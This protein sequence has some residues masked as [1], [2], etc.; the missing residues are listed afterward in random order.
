MGIETVLAPENKEDIATL[1]QRKEEELNELYAIHKKHLD[2]E[3]GDSSVDNL[4]L[5]SQ[6]SIVKKLNDL[7]SEIKEGPHLKMERLDSS[8]VADNKFFSVTPSEN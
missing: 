3:A 1:T 8:R 4:V 2:A 5:D 6:T 7:L